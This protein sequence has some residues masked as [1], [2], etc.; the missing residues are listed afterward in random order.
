[1]KIRQQKDLSLVAHLHL[2]GMFVAD[3]ELQNAAGYMDDPAR[4]SAP[5]H[6]NK[7]TWFDAHGNEAISQDG[8][9]RQSHYHDQLTFLC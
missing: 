2:G 3:H 7:N 6:L 5:K 8:M 1:V 4:L 9:R